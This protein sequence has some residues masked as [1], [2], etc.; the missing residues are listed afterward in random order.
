M[1]INEKYTYKTTPVADSRSVVQGEKYRFTVLT[2]RLIRLEY[3][4]TGSFEDRATQTVINRSFVP[5]PFTVKETQEQLSI[6]TENIELKYDKKQAFSSNSL[7]VHYVG[8]NS[9]VRA[10]GGSSYWY[11]NQPDTY[12]Y[13]GTARTLDKVDGAC[14]LERGLISY[15]PI[16]TLD[17]SKSLVI[18]EDGWVEPRQEG[19]VD[20]YLFCYGD[21]SIKFDAKGCLKDYYQLTGKTPLLPRYTLGNWWSRY[22]AYTQEEYTDL[23]NRFKAEDIPFSVAVIDMDWHNVK[24]DSKYGTGWT[25]YT[26]DKNLFPDHRAFLDFFL[27]VGYVGLTRSYAP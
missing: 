16:T 22:H 6:T 12:D 23:M 11:F 9:S 15:G 13:K 25:G 24:I 27:Y 10:G 7:S 5:V 17:D 21:S 8:R 20:M 1:R 2:S 18:C 4:E 14:E 26:W 19:N 3:S